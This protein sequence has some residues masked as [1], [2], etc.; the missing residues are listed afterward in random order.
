MARSFAGERRRFSFCLSI[1]GIVFR[2][3][4]G[5]GIQVGGILRA[6]RCMNRS[7]ARGVRE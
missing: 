3:V 7:N 2:G 6:S 4:L 5:Q 1:G